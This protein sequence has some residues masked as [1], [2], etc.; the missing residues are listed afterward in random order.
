MKQVGLIVLVSGLAAALLTTV[1]IVI[2]AKVW[3]YPSGLTAMM[4][5]SYTHLFIPGRLFIFIHGGQT[6]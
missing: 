6:H 3:G 2:D 5:V 4:A 1:V